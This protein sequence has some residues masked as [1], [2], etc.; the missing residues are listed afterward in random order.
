VSGRA[1]FAR[2]FYRFVSL[3]GLEYSTPGNVQPRFH[4]PGFLVRGNF[5]V[6]LDGRTRE[7]GNSIQH[8]PG[9]ADQVL[10]FDYQDVPG[11][12]RLRYISVARDRLINQ[13][14]RTISA[15][16]SGAG[17]GSTPVVERFREMGR[18]YYACGEADIFT[19]SLELAKVRLNTRPAAVI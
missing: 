17:R 9:I 8:L 12:P 5:L 2:E 19:A 18:V 16:R 15:T 13:S 1:K 11:V 14:W 10:E 6:L 4:C 3:G 7:F